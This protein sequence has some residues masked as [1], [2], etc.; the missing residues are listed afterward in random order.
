MTSHPAPLTIVALSGGVDSAV[1]AW[2]L[3]Q[4]GHRVQALHMTNWDADDAYCT[5]AEDLQA[6][7]R[8]ADQLGLVLHHVNFSDEYRARVFADFLREY[9]AGR[10]P[11]PDILCNREIKFGECLRH[12]Q[13]LGARYLATGHYAR[14]EP[15]DGGA[16]LLRARDENKDQTYFLHAVS[17][18]ALAS[19]VF[20]LGALTKD[21]VRHIA[22]DIGLDNWDRRDSTGICFIG[23]RPFAEFLAAHLDTPPGPIVDEHGNELGR[24]HGLACYTLGQR[25]G[26]GIGGVA[27]QPETPWYVA[28]RDAARN[29]LV[30]VQGRDHPALLSRVLETAVPAWLARPPLPW[31]GLARI[32]HRQPLEAC[33]VSGDDCS[34]SVRFDNPQRAVAPG[35]SVVFYDGE[36]CL[37]GAVIERYEPL[38]RVGGA[39]AT[40]G[41]AIM[42]N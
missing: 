36:Q 19:A 38:A 12:A 27:G 16:R 31:R 32:R 42:G 28:A 6:A 15:A 2:R 18:G 8:V 37:G 35:Q 11:N 33:T 26:L 1:A 7:R 39:S 30:V 20:P 22:R 17:P 41:A 34:L 5:A 14:V 24:H 3:L 21:E 10:T 4:D 13:R 23:E 9:A 25:G 40:N 29:A